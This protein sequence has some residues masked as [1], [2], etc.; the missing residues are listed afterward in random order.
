MTFF[1]HVGVCVFL[2]KACPE[3][4]QRKLQ[5]ASFWVDIHKIYI[6]K[7]IFHH[8]FPLVLLYFCKKCL[9]KVKVML[10]VLV[11]PLSAIQPFGHPL[12]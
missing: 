2:L 4:K 5:E 6:I 8:L 3:I 12:T 7:N 11:G 10:S 1:N 9:A